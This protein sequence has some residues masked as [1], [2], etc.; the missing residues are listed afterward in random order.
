MLGLA[1][2]SENASST[3]ERVP[4]RPYPKNHLNGAEDQLPVHLRLCDPSIRQSNRH[5][6]KSRLQR[7][8]TR[9]PMWYKSIYIS[10]EKRRSGNTGRLATKLP[11]WEP[12]TII[13][14]G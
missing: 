6:Q 5:T 1:Q 10:S 7:L 8:G 3:A 2:N 12:Q 4:R 14:S 13:G 9:S 11:S